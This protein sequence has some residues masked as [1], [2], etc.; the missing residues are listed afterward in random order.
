MLLWWTPANIGKC[1]LVNPNQKYW[2]QI[3]NELTIFHSQVIQHGNMNFFRFSRNEHLFKKYQNRKY[4]YK[5]QV[6]NIFHKQNTEKEKL[7]ESQII[8]NLKYA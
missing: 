6:I 7:V 2:L 3:R 1:C 4:G 5:R 8:A